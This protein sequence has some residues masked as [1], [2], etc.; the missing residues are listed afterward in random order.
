MR[1]VVLGD[2]TTAI[3]HDIATLG[4]TVER[5]LN[6]IGGVV[7]DIPRKSID[8]LTHTAGVRAVTADHAVHLSDSGWDPST[9]PG[10]LPTTAQ[11]VNATTPAASQATGKGVDVA[12]VDSGIA[13]VPGLTVPGKVVNGPDISFDSQNKS[14]GIY[15]DNYGH[16]T[17]IAGI[18]GGTDG[19]RTGQYDG[20]APDARLL[21]CGRHGPLGIE[22]C[23]ALGT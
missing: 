19:S 4:G 2:A 23:L 20:L 5:E 15:V 13:P 18:I 11:L 7:A 17:H 21:N 6:S 3:A 16:G 22:D 1:V 14:K 9:D 12:V 10:S 8:E